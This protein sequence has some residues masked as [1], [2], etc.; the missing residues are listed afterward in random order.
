MSSDK[1]LVFKKW[2]N[3]LP[4][5]FRKAKA[6]VEEYET[7]VTEGT[8]R[9]YYSQWRRTNGIQRRYKRSEKKDG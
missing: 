5:T 1:E 7:V 2:D 3:G 8:L 4:S 9:V 6:L